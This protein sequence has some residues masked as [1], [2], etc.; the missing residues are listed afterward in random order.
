MGEALYE[1]VVGPDKLGRP[2]RVYAPVG[3]HEDLL[4]YLVRR[5][6]E[7]GANT[8]FVNRLVDET[9]PV[10]EIVAD[11]IERLAALKAKPHPRIALPRD[12]YGDERKNSRGLD[13]G[14]PARLAALKDAPA[15]ARG[16]GQAA[17][18][19]AGTARP[20]AVRDARDPTDRHRIVGGVSDADEAAAGAALDAAATA[21]PDWAALPAGDRAAALDR[22]ADL[23]EERLPRFMAMIVREGGRTLPDALSEVREA[24]DHCRYYAARARAEFAAPLALPGPTGERNTLA[25]RGRGVFVC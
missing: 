20:G 21:A 1:Q 13:L 15:R 22:A 4:A 24:V 19:I 25:L 3:S 18:I 6:L 23:L 5:L 12:L 10:A 8:S 14:D 11:P 16:P 7:N 2:C 9:A 17:P